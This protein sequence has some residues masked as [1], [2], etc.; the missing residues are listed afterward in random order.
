MQGICEEECETHTPRYVHR[1]EVYHLLAKYRL[2]IKQRLPKERYK[3]DP[4]A[5][6]T[7]CTLIDAAEGSEGLSKIDCDDLE[8]HWLDPEKIEMEEVELEPIEPMD[9]DPNYGNTV[10]GSLFLPCFSDLMANRIYR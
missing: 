3:L 9:D 2:D 1:A 5:W 7:F 4:N 8:K 6:Q 10:S